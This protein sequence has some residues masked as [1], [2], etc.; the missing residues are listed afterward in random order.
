MYGYTVGRGG[1]AC[2]R[3]HWRRAEFKCVT[4]NYGSAKR[5]VWATIEPLNTFTDN[6]CSGKHRPFGS[7]VSVE[8]TKP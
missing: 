7:T 8:S 2:A 4:H 5:G 1:S 6:A 3:V